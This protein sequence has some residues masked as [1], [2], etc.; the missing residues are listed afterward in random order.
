MRKYESHRKWHLINIFSFFTSL[1]GYNKVSLVPRLS[2]KAGEEYVLALDI[3]AFIHFVTVRSMTN[4]VF[5]KDDLLERH[6]LSS[7]GITPAPQTVTCTANHHRSSVGLC[8]ILLAT[9]TGQVS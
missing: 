3:A 1:I 7:G 4:D 6:E 2:I 9:H 5:T 8:D